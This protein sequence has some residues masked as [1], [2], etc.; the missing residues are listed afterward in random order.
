LYRIG[1]R[2]ALPAR[3]RYTTQSP[4]PAKKKQG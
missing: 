4:R 2:S 1:G 3:Y